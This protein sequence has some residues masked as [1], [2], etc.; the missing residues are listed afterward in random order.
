MNAETRKAIS[1]DISA[2]EQIIA[3]IEGWRDDEQAKFDNMTEGLQQGE[4][5]Q[6]IEAAASAL[7]SAVSSAEDAKTYLEDSIA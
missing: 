4:K 1:A 6:A 5:G 2:L 7:E 3:N